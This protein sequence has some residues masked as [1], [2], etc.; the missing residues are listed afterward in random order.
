MLHFNIYEIFQAN[1]NLH[2]LHSPW[3][4]SDNGNARALL[5]VKKYEMKKISCKNGF[6]ENNVM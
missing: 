1:K 6:A 3:K 2:A 5:T 4:H